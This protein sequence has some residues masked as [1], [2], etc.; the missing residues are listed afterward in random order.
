MRLEACRVGD[1]ANAATFNVREQAP[2]PGAI[3]PPLL[4]N[5]IEEMFAARGELGREL[6]AD[7][8]ELGDQL[9]EASD[10]L[11]KA[12]ARRRPSVHWNSKPNWV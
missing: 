5:M 1:V 11:P 3:Q 12:E 10:P 6:L 7:R 2:E 8:L 9:V 4:L